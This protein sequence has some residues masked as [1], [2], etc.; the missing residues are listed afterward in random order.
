M[1]VFDIQGLVDVWHMLR[2][3][4]PNRGRLLIIV[5]L[6]GYSAATMC[7]DTEGTILQ[8]FVTFPPLSWSVQQYGNFQT[9]QGI[10]MCI[11]LTAAIPVLKHVVKFKETTIGIIA[12]VSAAGCALCYSQAV[13]SWIMFLALGVGVFR[14]LMTIYLQSALLGLVTQSETGKMGSLVGIIQAVC[15]VLSSGAFVKVF[16]ATAAWWPGFIF[17]IQSV[18]LLLPLGAFCSTAYVYRRKTARR[19]SDKEAIL[20]DNEIDV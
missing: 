10:V 14:P 8:L 17:A 5:T 7:L 1:R 16:G 13:Y 12:S 9:I 6:V 11:I 3:N 20:D 18:V 2:Q 19:A 15:L 4:R